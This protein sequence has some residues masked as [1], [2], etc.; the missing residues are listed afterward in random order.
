[1]PSS[2]KCEIAIVGLSEASPNRKV[3]RKICMLVAT[4]KIFM[5][6]GGLYISLTLDW[7]WSVML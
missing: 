5:Y 3:G 1:M 6:F 2:H 4:K 7:K